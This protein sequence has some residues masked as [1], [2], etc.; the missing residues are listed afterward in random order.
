[1]PYACHGKNYACCHMVIAGNFGLAFRKLIRYLAAIFYNHNFMRQRT[2]FLS[3]LFLFCSFL[4]SHVIAQPTWTLDPFGKEKKPEQY[5]DKLLPSEKTGNKKFTVMKR[6]M[7]N[8]TTRYNYYF[9]AENKLAGVIDRARIAQKDNY[10]RLL[11]FYPYS[12]ENT[13][14]QAAELDSVILKSTNGILLHD[15]RSDWVDNLYLLIG[16]AYYLRKDFDSAALTFQ[17]INYNLFPR[18]KKNYDDDKVVGSREDGSTDLSIASK[19]KQSLLQKATGLPPSRNDALIWLTRTFTDLAEYGDAAGIINILQKDDNMPARLKNDL[20]EVT[21]YWFYKQGMYDSCSVHLEKALSAAANMQD[22]SRWE[23]LLAQMLELNGNYNDASSYYAKAATHTVSPV[24]EIFARLNDAKMLRKDGNEK[25]LENTIGRLLRMAKKDKYDGYEHIIYYAAANLSLQRPDT[26]NALALYNKTTG[27]KADDQSYRNNAFLQLGDLSYM[28]RSYQNA[29]NYYDSLDLAAAEL[30][31]RKDDI[32]LRKTTLAKLVGYISVIEREDSLQK[33]A[34]M[35]VAERESLVKKLAR[36]YR[37]E[38]GLNIDEGDNGSVPITFNNPNALPDLF[39]SSSKGEWYFYNA[40]SRAKGYSDF[41]QKWGKRENADN[42]RRKNAQAS[43][44]NGLGAPGSLDD[45]SLIKG[46]DS[47]SLGSTPQMFTY[48]G[49]MSKLP[50][51]PEALDSSNAQIAINMI[52]LAQTF[53]NDLEDYPQAIETYNRYLSRFGGTDADAD[54]Y[55]GL[56]ICYT[57]LGETAKAANAKNILANKFANTRSGLA[58]TNPALLNPSAKNEA[59]TARYTDIYNKFIEGDF[60]TAMQAKARED[61]AYGTN[62]WTPQLVYL[63]ALY[64]INKREDSLAIVQ[65]KNL[66]SLYATSPLAEKAGTMIEVLGRRD[67]LERYL[68][69]LEITRAEEPKIIF[70]EEGDAKKITAQTQPNVPAPVAIVPKQTPKIDIPAAIATPES[71]KNGSFKLE[72]NEPQMLMMVLNKVDG[73]Y[74]NEAKNA[75]TRFNKESY[76]TSSITIARDVVDAEHTLLLFSSFADANAAIAYFD[77]IKK[78][79]PKE[80]PW[81]AP[82]KYSFSIISAANLEILK[83]NKDFEGYRQLLNTNF[84][85]KF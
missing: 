6:F 5:E 50:L 60:T 46:A 34:A 64:H 12:L 14:T 54:A 35:P 21:A 1:M 20:E 82:A 63:E 7:Q 67:S 26:L 17:F 48:E 16:K 29:F 18:S 73:V 39:N 47:T 53:Q 79:A 4:C 36:Q 24:M 61:S 37:K 84:N 9:N 52:G 72:P 68:T 80:V 85:N 65:L 42:W 22:R 41:R 49:M 58:V 28:Q 30:G 23:Y 33:I 31:E 44:V 69:N 51:T 56:Y 57:R 74:I 32:S 15:L 25:E 70:V 62:Y 8:A 38:N 43:I 83:S 78:A 11:S 2:A 10:S 27:Y 19:E 75:F 76:L 59:V 55:L 13:K 45:P 71:F 77:K 3:F 40:S 81:L 66:Q